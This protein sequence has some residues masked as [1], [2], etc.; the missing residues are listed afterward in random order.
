[1]KRIA[2]ATTLALLLTGCS[3]GSGPAAEE[4]VTP[5]HRPDQLP[6]G[7]DLI[8]YDT[9]LFSAGAASGSVLWYTQNGAL[10]CSWE[11]D[12][13][14][15]VGCLVNGEVRASGNGTG[16]AALMTGAP[17][18]DVNLTA[19]FAPAQGEALMVPTV[20]PE[21]Q[22]GDVSFESMSACEMFGF[23]SG[24]YEPGW[25]ATGTGGVLTAR[26]A[27]P[28]ANGNHFGGGTQDARFNLEDDAWDLWI[29]FAS[30]AK[31][32]FQ[33]NVETAPDVEHGASHPP[34]DEGGCSNVVHDEAV[35]MPLDLVWTPWHGEALQWR[36]DAE[37]WV[38]VEVSP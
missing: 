9:P 5:E 37:F 4:P 21:P 6:T 36:I 34:E 8:L 35:A 19:T 28:D 23:D 29:A 26:W 32:D 38:Y 3:D 12:A 24:T 11:A 25:R 33:I 14:I 10:W 31:Q 18:G 15:E 20:L 16:E 17:A 27:V 30:H 7:D 13:G 2:A 1:M 22:I